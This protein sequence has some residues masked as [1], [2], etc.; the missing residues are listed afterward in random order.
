M[1]KEI[2]KQNTCS[3][4]ARSAWA[5]HFASLLALFFSSVASTCNPQ[6]QLGYIS[7]EFGKCL[8]HIVADFQSF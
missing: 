6:I 3:A 8:S 2:E 5:V 7:T 1:K 4:P